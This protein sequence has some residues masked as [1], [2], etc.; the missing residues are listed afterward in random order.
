MNAKAAMSRRVELRIAVILP[1]VFG[2][3]ISVF[4][5]VGFPVGRIGFDLIKRSRSR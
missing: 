2:A 3:Y 1:A 5:S 4:T